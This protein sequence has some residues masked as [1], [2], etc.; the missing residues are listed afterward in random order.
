[1]NPNLTP[2]QQAG[3]LQHEKER[4]ERCKRVLE[5]IELKKLEKKTKKK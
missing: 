2:E 4:E 3:I 5:R 1:M